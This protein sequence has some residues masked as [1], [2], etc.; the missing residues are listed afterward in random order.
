L[1]THAIARA[2]HAACYQL[3]INAH[4][5][6]AIVL[7]QK[8]RDGQIAPC[9]GGVYLGCGAAAGAQCH[10]GARRADGDFAAF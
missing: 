6:M 1:K 7:M 9:R 8:A 4:I 2:D 5:R 10:A 3:G